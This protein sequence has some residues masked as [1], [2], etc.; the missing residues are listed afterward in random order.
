MDGARYKAMITH[1]FLLQ[2]DELGLENMWIQQDSTT[3]HTGRAT[4]D[5]LKEAFL[6]R[7]ISRFS[8]LRWAA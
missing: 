8:D 1:F 3:A 2:L 6:G 7:L 4:T 5:I